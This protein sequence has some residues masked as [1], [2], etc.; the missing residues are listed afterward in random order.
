M[1]GKTDGVRSLRSHQLVKRLEDPDDGLV[2][3][4]DFALELF[5]LFSHGVVGDE[6]SAHAENA[7]MICMLA[8]IARLLFRTD[9]SIAIPCSVNAERGRRGRRAAKLEVQVAPQ[10]CNLLMPAGT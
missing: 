6:H 7:R 10:V 9:E 5:E 8:A 4:A 2:V 1:R 3:R